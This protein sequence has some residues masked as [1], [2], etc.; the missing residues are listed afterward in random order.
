MLAHDTDTNPAHPPKSGS[1]SLRTRLLVAMA[2]ALAIAPMLAGMSPAQADSSWTWSKIAAGGDTTCAIR[3]D[4][5]LFCWGENGVSQLGKGDTKDRDTPTP[6][7]TAAWKLV[8]A[9]GSYTCGIRTSG[10]LYCW[11]INGGGP[12]RS[13]PTR[14]GTSTD[15]LSVSVGDGHAC[16][17]RSSGS[18]YC[19][20]YNGDG[21]LGLNSD[22]TWVPT[23]VGKY[24]TWAS[25]SAGGEHTCA[26]TAA[27]ILY[28]WG[29]DNWN[30][31]GDGDNKENRYEPTAVAPYNSDWVWAQVSAGFYHTCGIRLVSG[32]RQKY[33]WGS[34][35]MLGTDAYASG[36]PVRSGTST[37]TYRVSAGAQHSCDIRSSG[38]SIYCS[39]PNNFGQ[40][41]DGTNTF[42][43]AAV[44][45]YRRYSWNAL[46]GGNYHVCAIQSVSHHLYCWG[47]NIS[48][49]LGNNTTTKSS[50]P[51][52]VQ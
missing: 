19:W 23:R 9:G 42:R 47:R 49:Q 37:S 10:S 2:S 39:G 11:G 5:R 32:E 3:S 18:L 34:G 16:A 22:N 29:D 8:A 40:V 43:Y 25:V 7:G 24:Y 41:G 6:V 35:T 31:L 12:F 30:Q 21:R 20:G 15:W 1:A 17:I 51:V 45:E 52:R 48:G 13:T 14:V 26:I 28:C 33:C 4:A 36:I 27:G 50:I 38:R 44:R 46:D